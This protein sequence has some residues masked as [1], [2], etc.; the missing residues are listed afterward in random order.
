MGLLCFT[1][2][3]SLDALGIPGLNSESKKPLCTFPWDRESGSFV[4]S[5]G[6]GRWWGWGGQRLDYVQ[7]SFKTCCLWF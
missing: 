3:F 4:A 7:E 6:W 1:F 5:S 2:F